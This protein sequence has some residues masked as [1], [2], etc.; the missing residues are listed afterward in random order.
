[1]RRHIF[2]FGDKRGGHNFVV[3][4][5]EGGGLFMLG[6]RGSYFFEP[7]VSINAV[8]AGLM[9]NGY[10]EVSIITAPLS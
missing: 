5:W 10:D 7:R 9:I 1:M 2:G 4:V 3:R 6:W 8:T